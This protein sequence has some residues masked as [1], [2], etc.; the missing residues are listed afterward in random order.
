M[1]IGRFSNSSV[2]LMNGALPLWCLCIFVEA[3]AT[4]NRLHAIRKLL[5]LLLYGRLYDKLTYNST[6]VSHH[7][8]FLAARV[9]E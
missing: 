1:Y 6:F 7:V 9:S 5:L 4:V 8:Y 3:A 2:A